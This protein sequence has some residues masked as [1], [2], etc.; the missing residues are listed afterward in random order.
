MNR[1]ERLT[2]HGSTRWFTP[3]FVDRDHQDLLLP[4]PRTDG[5]PIARLMSRPSSSERGWLVGLTSSGGKPTAVF[6]R[7]HAFLTPGRSPDWLLDATVR[8]RSGARPFG[9]ASLAA[10]YPLDAITRLVLSSGWLSD[11]KRAAGARFDAFAGAQFR[12]GH[13]RVRSGYRVGVRAFDTIVFG[14]F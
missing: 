12:A 13:L 10:S 5:D 9:T 7:Q 14:V 6:G 11:S 1:R 2:V 4:P 3:L 8:S